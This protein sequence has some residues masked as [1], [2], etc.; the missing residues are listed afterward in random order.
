MKTLSQKSRENFTQLL[1]G[2]NFMQAAQDSLKYVRQ[3]QAIEK[4]Y[5]VELEELAK[6]IVYREYP[7][8]KQA[9]IKINAQIV[10][11]PSEMTLPPSGGGGEEEIDS[12]DD[13]DFT[14]EKKRRLINAI[15]Q[16]ASVRGAKSYYIFDDIISDLNPGLLEKYNELLNNTFGVYDDDDAIAMFMAMI[17]QGAPMGGGVS[18]ASYN[19]EDETLTINATALTFPFLVHE[20]IKGL[21]E[22]ISLQGFTGDAE[23]GERVVKNVDKLSNEPEDLRYG[24]FI[25]DALRDQV[26]D[27]VDREKYFV[28][29]YKLPD[30]EFVPFIENSISGKLTFL[31]KSIIRDIN[32]QLKEEENE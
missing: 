8:V 10:T 13:T 18:D 16:G 29:I 6:E 1:G 2:K 24:K 19:E 26:E 23:T 12:L 30:D 25:Y 28:E 32:Q 9:G 31:Q 22:I 7:I 4:D 14:P 11:N 21:Y 17:S 20:I 5:I 3:V 15:T 27:G